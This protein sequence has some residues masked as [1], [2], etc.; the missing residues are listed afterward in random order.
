MR[1]LL[2]RYAICPIALE[3]AASRLRRVC[4]KPGGRPDPLI[5]LPTAANNVAAIGLLSGRAPGMS[6]S[7]LN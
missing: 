1:W 3:Q 4:A 6:R 5:V 2:K 7:M